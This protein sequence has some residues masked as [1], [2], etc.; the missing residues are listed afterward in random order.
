M[1]AS[2]NHPNIASIYG[3]EQAERPVGAGARAGGRRDARRPLIAPTRR[4]CPSPRRSHRRQLADALDA[5][6]EN[7]IVHRDLKPAN[8]M[9]TPD[10][11]VKVLDF[12]LAKAESADQPASARVD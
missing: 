4:A 11:M 6:H 10:G 9:L 2:L 12:G 3:I 7:G 5:A 8:V 1:L